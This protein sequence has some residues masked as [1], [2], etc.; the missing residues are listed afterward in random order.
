MEMARQDNV[1]TRFS[2]LNSAI[3]TIAVGPEQRL[4][5]AHEDILCKSPFFAES[6][7]AQFF[8]ANG[9]RVDLP[10]ESPEVFSAILE[11]LYKGD[12]TPKINFDKKHGSWYLENDAATGMSENTI[13]T[14]SGI[15]ILKD[16]VLYVS[17][18]TLPSQTTH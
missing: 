4:F 3:V 1:L 10:A 2:N 13:Y 17:P 6:C 16:T 9:K 5:A 15:A 12:Y 7:R 11:Y 14:P 8:E 18:A